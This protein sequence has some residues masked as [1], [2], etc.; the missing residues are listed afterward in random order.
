MLSLILLKPV[1]A[2]G[3][4]LNCT[5]PGTGTS[6]FFGF[7]HWWQYMQ[8]STDGVTGCTPVFNGPGDIFPIGLAVLNILLHLA[9]VVAVFMVI[10]GG[11]EYMIAIGNPEKITGARR[12]I[13]HALVGLAIAMSAT[14]AV[15]FLGS[16]LGS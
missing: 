2:A 7:P 15:T 4:V 10:Y 11:I 9:G 1:F 5:L 8:G 6:S 14:A 16:K 12:G 13:V 3:K